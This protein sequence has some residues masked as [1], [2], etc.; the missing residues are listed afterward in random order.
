MIGTKGVVTLYWKT[1]CLFD[2]TCVG[3]V[4][5]QDEDNKDFLDSLNN[6]FK[7]LDGTNSVNQ[8]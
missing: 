3:V 2:Y 6:P 8:G 1:G 5:K 4:G 7:F